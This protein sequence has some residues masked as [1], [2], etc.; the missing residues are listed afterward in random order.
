MVISAPITPV[1]RSPKRVAKRRKVAVA[2]KAKR[3]PHVV[4]AQKARRAPCAQQTTG[5]RNAPR[6][7]VRKPRDCSTLRPNGRAYKKRLS[8][9]MSIISR[10][11]G[12]VVSARKAVKD[13]AAHD[14]YTTDSIVRLWNEL[15]AKNIAQHVRLSKDAL[16][17][18][19]IASGVTWPQARK[20]GLRGLGKEFYAKC[21]SGKV[22]RDRRHRRPI[23]NAGEI[24]LA[25]NNHS[26]QQAA[27]GR[28][29]YKTKK[30]VAGE[31]A[32]KVRCSWATASRQKPTDVK[33]SK[34]PCD[35]CPLC[36]RLRAHRLGALKKSG[37]KAPHG[38][39]AD[40]APTYAV[41]QWLGAP[42]NTPALPARLKPLAQHEL[43]AALGMTTCTT[44]S[45]ATPSQL[46]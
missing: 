27:G 12:S 16:L 24:Y 11:L 25:W 1:A 14:N 3:P 35:L 36:E 15:P 38:A 2:K 17:R 7:K 44:V 28:V 26:Y 4:P 45:A 8:K 6:L 32:R 41:K 18:P 22:L 40:E 29:F 31:V 43:P 34:R 13:L 23:K 37:W 30:Q 21:S 42:E 39:D 19:L 46:Y 33:R 9:V 5:V 20:L 10:H